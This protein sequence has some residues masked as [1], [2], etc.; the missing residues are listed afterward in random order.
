MD[1]GMKKHIIVISSLIVVFVVLFALH[2]TVGKNFASQY[3]DSDDVY[4]EG[5]RDIAFQQDIQNKTLTVVGLYPEFGVWNWYD[6]V[7][8]NGSANKPDGEIKI[9]DML[10]NCEGFLEIGWGTPIR[11]LWTADFR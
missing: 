2:V 6:I 9:G 3:G 8:I 4:Y 10:T 5:E 11:S 1:A 7:I